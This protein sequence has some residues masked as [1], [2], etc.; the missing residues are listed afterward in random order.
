MVAGAGVVEGSVAV[1]GLVVDVFFEVDRIKCGGKTIG[2][3]YWD[4]SYLTPQLCSLLRGPINSFGITFA[5]VM[6]HTILKP[7]EREVNVS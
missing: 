1:A 7:E 2:V 3:T 5:N 6:M 4:T